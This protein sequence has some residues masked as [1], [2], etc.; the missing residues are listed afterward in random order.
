MGAIGFG[1]DLNG[2]L[3]L[4]DDVV[5]MLNTTTGVTTNL[6]RAIRRYAVTGDQALIGVDEAADKAIDLNGDS[7]ANDVVEI[8]YDLTDTPLSLRGLGLVAS[9]F[10]FFRTGPAEVVWLLTRVDRS[11][12][13][14][15]ESF[16][17]FD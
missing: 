8:Y 9:T 3:D 16:R 1:V 15:P 12:A 2:D 7:Q 17:G 14:R 4:N 10:T 6:M 11:E 5:H 13:S